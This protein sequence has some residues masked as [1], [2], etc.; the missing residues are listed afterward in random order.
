MLSFSATQS[1]TPVGTSSGS[2]KNVPRYRTVT[3]CKANPNIM[4]GPRCWPISSMS[5]PSRKNSFSSI[6]RDSRSP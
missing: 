3:N 4:R 1:A 2:F 6:R 5:S